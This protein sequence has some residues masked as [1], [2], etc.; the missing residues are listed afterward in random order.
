LYTKEFGKLSVIAKGARD[1]KRKFGSALEPMNAVAAVLY[2]KEQHD[3]HL[4]TQCDLTEPFGR[5]SDDMER[6]SAAMT[7]VELIDVVTNGEEHN[8]RLFA[9]LVDTLRAI[10]SATKNSINALYYLEMKLAEIM[11]FQPNYHTCLHCLTPLDEHSVDSSGAEIHL[12][13]GG[14]A[15]SKCSHHS[16]GHER[17]SAAGV[18][19]LQRLQDMR[20]AGSALPIVLSPSLKQEVGSTLRRYLQRHIEHLRTLKSETVFAAIM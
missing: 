2:K 9:A 20:D 8:V 14:A 18:R 5:L 13:L 12:S 16:L 15:C 1:E 19:V 4:L 17:L 6:M 3:L 11:G 10:N 7:V